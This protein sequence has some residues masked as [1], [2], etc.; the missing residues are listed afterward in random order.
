MTPSEYTTKRDMTYISENFNADTVAV[1]FHIQG[2]LTEDYALESMEEAQEN[3]PEEFISS[4]SGGIASESI[5]SVIES[6]SR[7]NPE[8]HRLVERNDLNGNGVPDNN[9]GDIYD[10]L[11][12][13]SYR[14]Q[15]LAYMSENKRE[16]VVRYY[17]SSDSS[18]EDISEASQKLAEDHR[19]SATPTGDIIIYSSVSNLVLSSAFESFL[20]ALVITTLLLISSYYLLGRKATLGVANTFPIVVTSVLVIATMRF[21][22]IPFNALTATILAVT[23][24]VGVDYSV[25]ITHRFAEELD[26]SNNVKLSLERTLRGTGGALTGSLLTTV[27]GTGALVISVTPILKEFGLLMVISIIYSYATSILVL[28]PTLVLWE[29]FSRQGFKELVRAPQSPTEGSK[30]D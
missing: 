5:L 21:L 15:A 19:L 13:S 23:V 11:L 18:Y 27:V 2:R 17:V 30:S 20:A 6:Y 22:G 12:E 7:R 25:H 1:P 29:R 24:G 26:E 14:K 4:N 8:F 10:A 16:A 9:L 28:P 3:P